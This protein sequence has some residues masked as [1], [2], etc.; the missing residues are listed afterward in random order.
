MPNTI[1]STTAQCLKNG[2]RNSFLS[3]DLVGKSGSAARNFP[4]TKKR[5]FAVTV[6]F[7][8]YHQ[9]DRHFLTHRDGIREK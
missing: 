3:I 5:P 6:D 1:E 4:L 9:R 8:P 7:T 2:F